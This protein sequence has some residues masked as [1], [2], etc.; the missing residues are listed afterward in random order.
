MTLAEIQEQH[1]NIANAKN[2]GLLLALNNT[3]NAPPT[4]MQRAL[5]SLSLRGAVGYLP[6]T[7]HEAEDIAEQLLQNG[8]KARI[9]LGN[10]GTEESFR[11]LSSQPYHIVHIATHGFAFSETEL[12]QQGRQLAFL[13]EQT[14]NLDNPLN[15]SGL[16]LAGANY[17]LSG[18][19]LPNGLADGVLTAREIA[20]VDLS[21]TQ[22][23][24]L[25]ACQTGLG[26]IRDDG[27]F[28]IQRGFKKAGARSLLMSL[29]KVSDQATDLMM[30]TF[31]ERLVAGLPTHEAFVQAQQAVSQGGYEDPYYWASFILLDAM[32]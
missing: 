8:V 23:V 6:G 15:Y 1:D 18:N 4:D 16:L 24:V 32:E 9:L 14:D 27:V 28:G 21:H 17:V 2:S 19:K 13:N 11:A 3:D 31:Y 30:T 5:D 7:L 10:E 29:W 22:L 20:Q 12:K 26:E 25:S